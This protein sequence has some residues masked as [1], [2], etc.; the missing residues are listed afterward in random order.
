VLRVWLVCGPTA[1][2]P[3]WFGIYD[4]VD[5]SWYED[6][7]EAAY[8]AMC[9]A[10]AASGDVAVIQV[11]GDE[12]GQVWQLNTGTDDAGVAIA[13][14]ADFEF[15]LGGRWLTL[16]EARARV[17]AASGGTLTLAAARDGRTED[18]KYTLEAPLDPKATGE[19]TVTVTRPLKVGAGQV[20]LAISA[21]CLELHDLVVRATAEEER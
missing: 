11:A 9:E 20:T 10:E 2:E 8:T 13:C 3:N 12:D 19:E 7:Q 18:S 17:A 5:G 21:P 15:G 6:T 4:L 1:T 16:Q 14:R